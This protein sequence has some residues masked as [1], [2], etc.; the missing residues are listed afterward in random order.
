MGS[1][2]CGYLPVS[3]LD[4]FRARE[5]S[6]TLLDTAIADYSLALGS[7]IAVTLCLFFFWTA[8][9]SK[10]V[11]KDN[12]GLNATSQCKAASYLSLSVTQSPTFSKIIYFSTVCLCQRGQDSYGCAECMYDKKTKNC[13]RIP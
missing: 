13:I 10:V 9:A 4:V 6:L 1:S 2:R 7:T 12:S 5:L 11:I 8:G 3:V